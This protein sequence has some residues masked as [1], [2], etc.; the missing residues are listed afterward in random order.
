MLQNLQS[1]NLWGAG[2]TLA[3]ELAG[4][5]IGPSATFAANV[6]P[7]VVV[8]ISATQAVATSTSLTVEGFSG[9]LSLKGLA[10]TAASGL[11]LGLE[12]LEAPKAVVDA[13]GAGFA[14][15]ICGIMR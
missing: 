10:Q 4:R 9:A 8:G 7:N 14:A 1:G 5:A 15:L 6:M 13:A 2:K 12:A 3:P 11:N